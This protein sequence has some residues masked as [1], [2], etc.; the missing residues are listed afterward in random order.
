MRKS[1]ATMLAFLFVAA[2][3]LVAVRPAYSSTEVP[4]NTWVLK[5]PMH[6][7]R[8]GLGVAVVNGK[9]YAIGGSTENGLVGINEAY[10]PETNMWTYRKPMPTPRANFHLEVVQNKIYCLGGDTDNATKTLANEV[11]DP[12]TDT[13]ETRAPLP[14]PRDSFSTVVL[15]NRIY[16]IGGI[17]GRDLAKELLVT[18]TGATEVYDPARD[19][20]ETKASIQNASFPEACVVINGKIYVISG[21]T[22]YEESESV[23]SVYDDDTN[24]WTNRT[25]MPVVKHGAAAVFDDK[26][27]FIGGSYEDDVFVTLL[28]IYDPA[29]DTWSAGAQ[30]PDGGVS[31]GSVFITTG[32][33]SPI[34]IYVL[35][36]HLRVYD[37]RKDIWTLGPSKVA[38]RAFMG[39]AILKDK[40]YAIGGLTS[41]FSGFDEPFG[42]DVT[43][44]ATNEVYTPVGYG[45]SDS[46]YLLATTPPEVLLLAPLNQTYANSNVSLV[47]A[48]DK[49]VNWSSYSLDGKA[50]VTITGNATL[51]G[52]SSDLHNVTVYARD[53]FGNVGA[54]E[55]IGFSVAEASFPVV[56]VAVASVASLAVVGVGLMVYFRRRNHRAEGLSRNLD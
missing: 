49:P 55:T 54:S 8:S 25:P 30:P 53:E 27:Y 6:E 3:C 19:Q 37:P 35:E 24:S 4:E 21:S 40:I 26:I 39:I 50:N 47:F 34:R 44:Y 42:F 2:S 17:T 14:T 18:Y 11:Y 33:V 36:D 9:I 16:V 43:R 46:L 56:P 10:D 5:A 12:A 22:T 28:Q 38:N 31:Q 51:S 41:V 13:W 20:W 7:A 32:D 52:L 29:N 45:M 15:R 48:V 1:A 23:T